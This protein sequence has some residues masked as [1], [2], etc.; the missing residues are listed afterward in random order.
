MMPV[1]ELLEQKI[2]HSKEKFLLKAIILRT[3]LVLV[4]FG[5]AEIFAGYFGLIMSFIGAVSPN[6]LGF[7]LPSIFY[8]KLM[9][10]EL[11]IGIKIL[12]ILIVVFGIFALIVCVKV[13]IDT[14]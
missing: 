2:I 5:I 14:L 13:S 6:T 9:W 12:N 3:T 7:V 10:R 8:L 1:S 11:N 4:A